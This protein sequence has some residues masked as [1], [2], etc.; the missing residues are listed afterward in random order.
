[1]TVPQEI[2]K[3]IECAEDI[4]GYMKHVACGFNDTKDSNDYVCS[5]HWYKHKWELEWWNEKD[6]LKTE[7]LTKQSLL[8]QLEQY[9]SEIEGIQEA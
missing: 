5:I 8:H 6:H 4:K 7:H 3:M 2:I 1:M 9:F